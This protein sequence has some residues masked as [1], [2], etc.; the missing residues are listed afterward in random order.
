[1]LPQISGYGKHFRKLDSNGERA[2]SL[3]CG[4]A[5][6]TEAP[7]AMLSHACCRQRKVKCPEGTSQ[8]G[9]TVK[10]FPHG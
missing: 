3:Q 4:A 5:C 9:K 1:M 7:A 2:G 10:V 8:S 6:S